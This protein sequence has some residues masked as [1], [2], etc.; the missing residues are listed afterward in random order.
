MMKQF[1]IFLLIVILSVSTVLFMGCKI[2]P[3]NG[4]NGDDSQLSGWLYTEGNK[5]FKANGE[6]WMGRGANLQDTRGCNAC[7]WSSPDVAEVKRRIDELVDVWGANFIRLTL[8]SYQQDWG[9]THWQGLL[10]DS[11]YFDDIKE[12]VDWIGS[13]TGVYVLLSLWSEPTF[14]E[15][16]W[17]TDNTIP[18]WEKLAETFSD[19]S[20]VLYGVANEPTANWNGNLDAQCWEAMNKVVAAIRAVEQR[21]G[22]RN[23]IIA[24]QGTRAWARRLDYYITHPITAGNGENI[25]YETHVYDTISEFQTL[26]IEPAETLPVIIGEFGPASGYMSMDDCREL[27]IRAESLKIPYLAW[28][29]HMR[30][31]PNL[32]VD[33][34][35]GGCGTNMPLE[36]TPWGELLI[37]YLHQSNLKIAWR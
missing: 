11:E 3:G 34:S 7:T 20:Y 36:P 29:F 24:V 4:G 13:K 2:K 31:P 15:M 9:R 32:L 16:G 12:I 26:F 1:K 6:I 17:P 28:T 19:A 14:S 10:Q 21:L 5:I 8:E 37:E 33:Y 22:S 25:I 23:H 35:N 30:C 18:I 27:I